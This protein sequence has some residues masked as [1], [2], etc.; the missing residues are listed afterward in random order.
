MNVDPEMTGSSDSGPRDTTGRGPVVPDS[1]AVADAIGQFFRALR[2]LRSYPVH[3]EMSQRA[4][5]DVTEQFSRVLPFT[6][7]LAADGL[8]WDQTPVFDDRGETPEL[9][10]NLFKD[11]VRRIA[12]QT[13]LGRDEL[14]RFLVALG[15]P[16][17]P[18]DLSEDYVTRLWEADL[19]SVRISAID[20]YL[21][22]EIEGDVMEGTQEPSTEVVPNQEAA[23]VP[24]PP[25]DAFQ[26][27]PDVAER[28]AAEVEQEAGM[29]RWQDFIQAGFQALS[30][31]QDAQRLAGVVE[32][33]E[34][35]FHLFVR[36]GQL[37]GAA[38][39]VERLKG[40]SSETDSEPAQALER[41]ADADRLAPLHEA[42]ETK[43]CRP[44]EIQAVLVQFGHASAD[45]VCRFLDQSQS[46]RTRRL[47]AQTL[48]Q[49]GDPVKDVAVE[50]FRRSS[51]DQ[52]ASYTIALG[53]MQGD[54]VVSTLLEA[55]EDPDPAVRREGA[56]ALMAQTGEKATD[57]LCGTALDDDAEP[58]TRIIAL[59]GLCNT[60]RQLD[61]HILLRRIQSRQY[62]PLSDEEKMLLF[63][64]L[65][66]TG[67]DDV[68]GELQRILTPSWIPGRQRR[69]DWKH[70]A[71]ALG[72]LGTPRAIQA[73][74]E[75][76]RHRNTEL[77]SVCTTELRSV[78]KNT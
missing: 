22:P 44:E 60:Q 38:T 3:N 1:K 77:A 48:G 72:R 31:A 66:A 46:P 7:Q 74:E 18:D 64:A 69:D 55:M 11:G 52:R 26:I 15:Q 57:A 42:L 35:Y 17:D 14:Q 12:F 45:T 47:Y 73:L 65:G 19:P 41:M 49:I 23:A 30:A 62:R 8:A 76:S 25:D 32:A 28:V 67:H 13:D 68:V 53:T 4:M 6:L 75:L 27:L 2:T 36:E 61:Y 59:R 34:S 56:R 29:T 20:P 51:G 58:I 37:A 78:R 24:P 40:V 43:T 50:G 54:D 63:L 33:L 9:V 70:A 71:S 10:G 16:I 21:D 5:A 39:I